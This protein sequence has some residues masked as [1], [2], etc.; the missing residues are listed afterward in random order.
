MKTLHLDSFMHSLLSSPWMRIEKWLS[1][2]TFQVLLARHKAEEV[3][4]AVK[5]L[6]KKAILK[7]KE[8]RVTP[9]GRGSQAWWRISTL[10]F[11]ALLKSEFATKSHLSPRR[12][13]LC[14]SGMFC[15]RMWST[16][17]WWAFTSHSRPLT[18]STLSWTTLMVE[19]WA[20]ASTLM[21]GVGLLLFALL[22]LGL[23]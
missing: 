3:F 22:G 1:D 6:Q 4:Y 10:W 18:S 21:V 17:S 15:W 14:Q 11:A 20:E 12:S 19:R 13:I 23:R 9:G 16:L 7:K 8:V 5:V 2:L